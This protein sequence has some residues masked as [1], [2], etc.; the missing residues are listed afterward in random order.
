MNSHKAFEGYSEKNPVPKIEPKVFLQSLIDP[1]AGTEEK[2]KKIQGHDEKA[3][4]EQDATEKSTKR[5]TK[6]LG[7]RFLRSQVARLQESR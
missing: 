3:E 1:S 5:M 6:G 4:K 7:E 2:A